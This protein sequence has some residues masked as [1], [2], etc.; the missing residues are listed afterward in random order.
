MPPPRLSRIEGRAT[1]TTTASTVTTK[2]PRTAAASV[3]VA[4]C[5]LRVPRPAGAADAGRVMLCGSYRDG[6]GAP[7][8]RGDVSTSP[9]FRRRRETRLRGA[10]AGPPYGG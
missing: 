8:S 10:L 3:A 9:G 6:I 5:D 4:C 7:P 2:N 1:F